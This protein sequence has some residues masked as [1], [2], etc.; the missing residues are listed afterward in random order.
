MC[1]SSYLFYVGCFCT[2]AALHIRIRSEVNM[3]AH[4]VGPV[5][6]N[7]HSVQ[8]AR[9]S[10]RDDEGSLCTAQGIPACLWTPAF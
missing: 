2:S 3:V 1:V 8:A 6:S 9:K 10:N 7:E 4:G 5:I